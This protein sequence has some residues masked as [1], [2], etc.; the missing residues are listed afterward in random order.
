MKRKLATI[1]AVFCTVL[2]VAVFL[3]VFYFSWIASMRDCLFAVCGLALGFMFAPIVHEM[4][5]V[6]FAT[7]ANMDVVYVKCFCL[8]ISLKNGKKRFTLASPFAADQTQV[9]PKTGGDMQRRAQKYTVGGLV[10]SA[11]F[12]LL[13]FA[14]ALVSALLYAPFYLLWGT[15]PYSAYLLLL[16]LAP[17]EYGAGKTDALVYQGLKKGADVEKNLVSAME[18]HGQLYEGKSF[19]QIDAHWYFSQPQLC[20]DEPLF[21]VTLD[22]RYRYYLEKGDFE[23]AADCLNRLAQAQAY[24]P[25]EEIE[26]IAAELVYMHSLNGDLAL[27]NASFAKSI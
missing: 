15:L 14:A 27:A 3:L 25:T 5:H 20:E 1:Y 21:A 7:A 17:V 24:L 16:N 19:A 12:L 13:L 8:K 23:K 10:F 9:I 11:I 2:L 18:I 6:T 22:L 4:G 26:K